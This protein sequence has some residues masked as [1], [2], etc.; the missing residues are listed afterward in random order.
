MSRSGWI[1]G[2]AADAEGVAHAVLW[3]DGVI[4]RLT[5]PGATDQASNALAVNDAGVAA[6]NA[7]RPGDITQLRSWVW[8]RGRATLLPTLPGGGGTQA[9]RINDRGDVVG[10]A[11]AEDGHIH[12]VL[13]HR[14][15]IT[16]LG[17]P[18]A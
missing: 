7:G 3:R 6:V 8:R 14:G 11:V 4:T 5:I 15:R 9:R 2:R 13:W 18:P 10:N 1:A 16:D 12:P 17:L